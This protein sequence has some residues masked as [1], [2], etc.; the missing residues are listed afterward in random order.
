MFKQKFVNTID[1]KFTWEKC[2][3]FELVYKVNL[4]WTFWI[5]YIK[6]RIFGYF[7]KS[8][9][10]SWNEKVS[11]YFLVLLTYAEHSNELEKYVFWRANYTCEQHV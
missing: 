6:E 3:C 8:E 7:W 4:G 9:K 5:K 11:I 2:K 1:W 10:L